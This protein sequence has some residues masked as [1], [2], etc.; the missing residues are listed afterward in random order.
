MSATGRAKVR[1][2]L[3][4]KYGLESAPSAP[5]AN[6]RASGGDAGAVVG[7]DHISL[8]MPLSPEAVKAAVEAAGPDATRVLRALML[9]DHE[10]PIPEW[11]IILVVVAQLYGDAQAKGAKGYTAEAAAVI[12]KWE[13]ICRCLCTEHTLLQASGGASPSATVDLANPGL[14]AAADGAVKFPL[15]GTVAPLQDILM[16]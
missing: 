11:L 5:A 2:G 15:P 4:N 13:E 14:L 16:N 10:K 6:A 3:A 9:F 1:A 12:A 7:A 8:A